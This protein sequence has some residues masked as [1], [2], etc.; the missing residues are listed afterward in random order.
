MTLRES[1]NPT[2]L[3][4]DRPLRPHW[5][6]GRF[7]PLDGHGWYSEKNI[8]T[9][10]RS[11]TIFQDVQI[12]FLW[13]IPILHIHFLEVNVHGHPTALPGN[14][15]RF[16][17]FSRSCRKLIKKKDN[18]PKIIIF[19]CRVSNIPMIWSLHPY[20]RYPPF[21]HTHCIHITRTCPENSITHLT[22]LIVEYHCGYIPIPK[23]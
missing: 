3:R 22:P 15:P 9:N 8:W 6:L 13:Q 12:I 19:N 11:I 5:I 23:I 7:R 1:R 16:P 14:R 17:S 18:T 20:E 4:R 2:I 21:P 10:P